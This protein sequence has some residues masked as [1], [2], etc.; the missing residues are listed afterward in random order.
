M[1][2]LYNFESQFNNVSIVEGGGGG[3]SE[4]TFLNLADALHS[5]C[6]YGR[7]HK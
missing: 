5:R 4:G 2:Q 1:N 3:L 7:E 6:W